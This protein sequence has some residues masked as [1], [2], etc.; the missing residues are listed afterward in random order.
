MSRLIYDF[1]ERELTFTALSGNCLWYL[2]IS[3]II[4]WC[5]IFYKKWF[6]SSYC[7]VS[8]WLAQIWELLRIYLMLHVDFSY[9][10]IQR[11]GDF[12]L[13]TVIYMFD[14]LHAFRTLTLVLVILAFEKN[15][16]I[17]HHSNIHVCS[18]IYF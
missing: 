3:I 17:Q 12:I 10:D 18:Y 13:C 16:K 4:V 8:L 11:K 2:E 15:H 7:D 1:C 14:K 5:F 9:Y 6:L